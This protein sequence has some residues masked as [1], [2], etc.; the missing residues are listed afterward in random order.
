MLQKLVNRNVPMILLRLLQYWYSNRRLS[1][2]WGSKL[3]SSFSVTKGVRQGGVLSPLLFTVCDLNKLDID[4]M[5]GTT[6]VN[7]LVYAVDICYLAPSLKGL[8]KLVDEC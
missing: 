8:Q 7:H 2:K 4:C 6:C 3:S 1:V 5:V